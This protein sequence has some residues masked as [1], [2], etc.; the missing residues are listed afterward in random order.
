MNKTIRSTGAIVLTLLAVTAAV[1]VIVHL[2]RYYNDAPWTRDAYVR[3]DVVK[4]APDVSGLV[5]DVQVADNA[6]VHKG[7]VLFVV[8]RSHYRLALA[9]AKADVAKARA[10]LAQWRREVARDH[11][12]KG[13]VSSESAEQNR[14]RLDTAKATLD[15]AKVAQQRAELDMHRTQ[16]RS[17]VDGYVNDRTVRVG[18][19]VSTG[20]PVLSVIDR[21]SMRI[22]GF[23]EETKLGHIH[24]GDAVRIRLM[25]AQH[26]LRGHVTS[27]AWGIAGKNGSPSGELLPEVSPTF[28]WV[29]L[30]QRIPVR[31]AIDRVPPG[32]RLVVGRTAT[33]NVLAGH[34]HKTNGQTLHR[35][36]P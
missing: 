23:F 34:P 21:H 28:N 33:V 1:F 18:D 22:D 13:L 15:A 11:H 36:A 3:A 10:A 5:T 9:Q 27:I 30:A 7:Q 17:P 24:V 31:I 25:G 8:D 20:H 16:V 14:A 19:Y 26:D 29:R 6:R 32:L 4:V 35:E 12:L 2:W